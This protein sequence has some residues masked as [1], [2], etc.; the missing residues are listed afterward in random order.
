MDLHAAT[1]T[2]LATMKTFCYLKQIP[3][4]PA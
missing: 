2:K 3:L 1:V 4:P